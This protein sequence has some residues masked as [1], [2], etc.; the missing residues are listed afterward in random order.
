MIQSLTCTLIF[1]IPAIGMIAGL[2]CAV[3]I[4]LFLVIVLFALRYQVK[5]KHFISHRKLELIFLFWCLITIS[6][7]A[8][9]L[10]AISQYVGVF[11]IILVGIFVHDNLGQS[12]IDSAKVRKY[13]ILGVVA[14]ILLLC[15]EYL[16]NGIIA[17]LIRPIT[18]A[19]STR[20]FILSDLDRGCALLSVISW[21]ML[22]IFLQSRKY[23]LAITY[24]FL[25]LYLLHISDSLASFLAFMIGGL[26]F[27]ISRLSMTSS[28]LRMVFLRFFII[29]IVCGSILM[30]II[31]YKMQP[32][33][34]IKIAKSYL[35][36][37][38]KH[39]LFIWH[40]VAQKIVD[41]PILGYGFGSSRNF[42]V[43]ENE[44]IQ[45]KGW[46]WSPFP[47]H[48]HNNII[49]IVFETGL[50]GLLLFLLLVYK[51]LLLVD[52]K[53]NDTIRENCKPIYYACF[54]NY[55]IIGMIS[56]SIWQTWW[57]ST[58]VL[59]ACLMKLFIV[60]P[61]EFGATIDGANPIK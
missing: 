3:T 55:Y 59:A 34:I 51:N 21:A 35:P 19:K 49:Q 50:I 47:A 44:M 54:T 61:G 10:P 27:L 13:F 58:A 31:S 29:S 48:P 53:K 6:Y 25:V 4:P 5:F 36:D 28:L 18:Q 7:S 17:N 33:D 16:F 1:L 22:A 26:V 37:S 57:I 41:K 9:T 30:P 42:P 52:M 11:I 24:Y 46:V 38:A 23:L 40:F 8:N 14:G 60:N 12:T 43:K 2:S 20:T 32:L 15:F 39:R 56:Y 45:Y